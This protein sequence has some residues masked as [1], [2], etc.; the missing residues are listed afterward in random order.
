MQKVIAANYIYI[1]QHISTSDLNI[2]TK[3]QNLRTVFVNTSEQLNDPSCE[4]E[5]SRRSESP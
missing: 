3:G 4:I 5:K 2:L 1:V